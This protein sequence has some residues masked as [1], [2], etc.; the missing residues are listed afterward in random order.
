MRF[1][2][3]VFLC[4]GAWGFVVLVPLYFMLD[5]VGRAYPPPITH[6][7]FYYGFVGVALIWQLLFLMIATDPL[8]FRPAMIAAVAEKLVYVVTLTALYAGGR[9]Q[10]GQAAV[11][12][13]DLILG[14][15]FVAAFVKTGGPAG[16]VS[17]AESR[18]GH[19]A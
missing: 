9:I 5:T 7:D 4:A 13:P 17:D 18:P 19:S 15:L 12:A 8:R 3:I 6:P 2:R 1:A 10:A 11:A 16:D 14:L